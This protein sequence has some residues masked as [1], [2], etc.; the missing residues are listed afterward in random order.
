[1]SSE[2]PYT[3][4]YV[5][6]ARPCFPERTAP[7][8]QPYFR[9]LAEDQE[10]RDKNSF[11]GQVLYAKVF[12]EDEADND[13]EVPNTELAKF[14]DVPHDQSIRAIL[15]AGDTGAEYM[16]RHSALSDEDYKT[17]VRWIKESVRDKNPMTL[18][19]VVA[20]AKT[21]LRK[22]TTKEALRKGLKWMKKAR[23]IDASPIQESR[24]NIDD[25]KVQR[26]MVD[27]EALLHDVP[28]TPSSIWT[29]RV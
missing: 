28:H 29:K 27:A 14:F 11:R 4:V 25:D 10:F 16:G 6:E 23:I 24:L 19:E 13:K 12:V 5:K 22:G 9:R 18:E 21:D 17:I 15:V 2:Q 20:R 7:E 26:F 3:R 1:M 8:W